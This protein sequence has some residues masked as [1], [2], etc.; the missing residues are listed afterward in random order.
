MNSASGRSVAKIAKAASISSRVLALRIRSSRPMARAAVSTSRELAA[1]IAVSDGLSSTATRAA[2]GT[3]S[4]RSSSR[5]AASSAAKKLTPVRLPPGRAR[6]ETR[7]SRTGSSATI[8]TI[9]IE[10]GAFAAA[11]DAG[12]PPETSTAMRRRARSATDRAAGLPALPPSDTRPR[13][14]RPQDNRRP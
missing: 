5:F 13:S 12:P 6:L 11:I 8:K 10:V 4:R 9:G 7:P 2:A 1:A 3:S 14:S